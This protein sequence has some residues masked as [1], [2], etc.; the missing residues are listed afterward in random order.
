M[1]D[2]I[3][4]AILV[5]LVGLNGKI[6]FDWL[7]IRRNG[8]NPGHNPGNSGNPNNNKLLMD[9]AKELRSDV[10]SITQHNVKVETLL[11]GILN[12][13]QMQRK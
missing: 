2:Q 12:E 4:M 6:V 5:M 8:G 1:T 11:D 9:I 13:I 7:K 3:L 10:K